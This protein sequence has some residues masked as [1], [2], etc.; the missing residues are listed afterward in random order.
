MAPN[1]HICEHYGPTNKKLRVFLPLIVPDSSL[2]WIRV[3]HEKRFLEEG[4][5]LI[6]DDSFLHDAANEC[7][8]SPRIVLIL[9]I[10]HPD[11]SEEEVTSSIRKSR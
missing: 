4:K 6:F 3:N 1:T 10:W 8:E 11:L 5:C 2:C 7:S 9:D